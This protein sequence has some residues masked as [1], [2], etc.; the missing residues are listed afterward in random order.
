MLDLPHIKFLQ[1][2]KKLLIVGVCP[3]PLGGVSVHV[4]R[5][6]KLL[7]NSEIY[8]ISKKGILQLLNFINLFFKL[9]FSD[10]DAVHIHSIDKYTL[11]IVYF[12]SKI[13]IFNII[14][15]DHNPRTFI[16][17]SESQQK[18]YRKIVAKLD[19][20]ILVGDH[21]LKN[22]ESQNVTLPSTIFVEPAFLP[23]PLIEKEKIVKTY[24]NDLQNFIEKHDYIISA[25]AFQLAMFNNQDLYGLDMC[26]NLM[27][28]LKGKNVGFIFALAND[29]FNKTYLSEQLKRIADNN[30]NE[31]FFM[32]KGQ[33]EIW[34]LF[35]NVDLLV[36]PTNT[37]GD[38]VSIK[39][40][41]HFNCKVI[42]S[43]VCKRPNNVILF[44]TRDQEDFNK[45]CLELIKS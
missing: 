2:Y 37:D 13:R 4:Y 34:P 5:L 25:N 19:A 33:R 23:P 32:L 30:L 36:R 21:V 18:I 9:I 42:A 40:A 15:T 45:K 38:A 10:F 14:V 39:E 20:I 26:V 7:S 35:E 31:H 1:K 11:N 43:D 41:L 3:P 12:A 22:Y 28:D 44:N 27:K 17:K 6:N 24:P 29:D 8:D 16:N